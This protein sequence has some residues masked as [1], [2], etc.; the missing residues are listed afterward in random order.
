[1]YGEHGDGL[2]HEPADGRFKAAAE[3][4]IFADIE[5]TLARLGIRFDSYFNEDTLYAGGQIA[6]IL[7]ELRGRGLGFEQDGAVWLRGAPLGLDKD[8]V[9]VKSSGEP[10]YRLPDIAYHKEKLG[11]GFD[12]LIDVLGAD[13]IAEHEEV[14][15][16]LR[17]L[18]YP[19]DAI[20]AI[21]YQ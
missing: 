18:G 21:I 13:H 1:L 11:R 8:R 19:V 20:E 15:A 17:G 16:A 5:A 4:A 7:A 12:L 14:R 3:R 6:A 10:A 2:R 9:L